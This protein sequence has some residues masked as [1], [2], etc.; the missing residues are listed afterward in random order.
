MDFS[1]YE[2]RTLPELHI[3]YRELNQKLIGEDSKHLQHELNIITTLII[4]AKMCAQLFEQKV[5]K[6]WLR[7][8]LDGEFPIDCLGELFDWCKRTSDTTSRSHY[9]W[10]TALREMKVYWSWSNNAKTSKIQNILG[11]F[12]HLQLLSMDTN[13]YTA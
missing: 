3:L 4:K 12:K 13:N 11:E 6:E 5:N 2:T 8:Y 7:K 1:N 9:L 10:L